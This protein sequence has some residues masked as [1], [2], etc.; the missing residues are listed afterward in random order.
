MRPKPHGRLGDQ[1]GLTL[2]EMVITIVVI[3]IA[4]SGTLV[5]IQRTIASSADPMIVRRIMHHGEYLTFAVISQRMQQ[6]QGG[7]IIDIGFHICLENHFDLPVGNWRPAHDRRDEES[8]TE[9]EPTSGEEGR[10][11]HCAQR[12]PRRR[13]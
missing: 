4:I 11:L 13:H 6:G 2:I 5:V 7:G 9:G 12:L 1:S 8:E 3:S 10:G